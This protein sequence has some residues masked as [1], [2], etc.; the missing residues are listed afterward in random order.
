MANN[1]IK[2]TDEYLTKILSNEGYVYLNKIKK[3]DRTYVNSICPNGN[4]YSFY[5]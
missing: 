1:K 4:N 2:Y 3:N 5:T